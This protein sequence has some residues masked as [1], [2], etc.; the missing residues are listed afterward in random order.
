MSID[1]RNDE[2]QDVEIND[3]QLESVSGGQIP[4]IP[5]APEEPRLRTDLKSTT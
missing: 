1:P 2:K 4:V 3:E 5:P